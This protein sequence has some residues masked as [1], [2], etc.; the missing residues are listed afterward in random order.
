[1]NQKLKSKLAEVKFRKKL[2]KQQ[3]LK[4]KIFKDEPDFEK[5]ISI[6]KERVK[7]SREDFKKLQEKKILTGPYLELGAERCQRAMVLENEFNIQ[8]I[9]TDI[10]LDS[11]KSA[12]Y[13]ATK[14]GFKKIPQRIVADAYNL[15]FKNNSFSFIFTY[16]T[17]HH[18]PNPQPI[19]KEIFRILKN[20]GWLFFAE[21]PLKQKFNLRLWK[22]PT[23]LR[24][25][26]KLLKYLGLLPFLSEIGKSETEEGILETEFDLNTWQNSL[27]HF[28]KVIIFIKPLYGPGAYLHKKED[29]QWTRPSF[30][31]MFLTNIL[32]GG[33]KVLAYK[34]EKEPS[35]KTDFQNWKEIL[36][37]PSCKE[38]T[39]AKNYSPLKKSNHSIWQCEICKQKFYQEDGILILLSLNLQKVLYPHLVKASR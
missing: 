20:K 26:E 37:C 28:Q 35:L 23:K 19:L 21:E 17:L 38:N 27:A 32:G 2:I 36:I 29:N 8:G 22:R 3:V 9:A 11:L 33:I 15:P 39:K 25:W 30:L 7:I 10:S 14:L 18:F 24:W 4:E 1:M 31:T 13:F 12:P 6:L 16:Q 34:E 5:I